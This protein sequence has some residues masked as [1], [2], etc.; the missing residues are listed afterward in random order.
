MLDTAWTDWYHN[1]HEGEFY[2]RSGESFEEYV[3][4]VLKQVY[5]DFLNPD[6]A[7]SSGDRGCDGI[8]EEGKTVYA[9]YGKSKKAKSSRDCYVAGKMEDD[10]KKA[11][12][13]W[14]EMR[15]WR[16]VT[17]AGIGPATAQKILEL[18]EK[19]SESNSTRPV[20]IRVWGCDDLWN[21]LKLLDEK[22]ITLILPPAPHAQDAK[23]DDIVEAIKRIR[24][25]DA[26]TPTET[27]IGEV[28]PQKMDYNE[29][30]ELNRGAFN[31][32]RQRAPEIERWFAHQADAELYDTKAKLLKNQYIKVCD[33]HSN[34]DEILERIFIYVGGG[35]FRC[36]KS[37][38][39]AVYAVVSYFF[40][41]CDIFKDPNEDSSDER[42]RGV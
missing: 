10:L 22:R 41:R 6:P 29:I 40:D 13:S 37:R 7:G 35:D 32:G 30:G 18:R 33:T 26:V 28:S 25:D 20:D 42:A 27:R 16:F 21:Q 1:K 9:C 8:A 3:S 31:Q 12:K 14:P 2:S 24:G 19:Y 15:I 23:F 11:V 36:D 17:N 39:V 38:E 34:S 5:P 4:E